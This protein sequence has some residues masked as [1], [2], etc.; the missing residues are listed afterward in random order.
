MPSGDF[1]KEYSRPLLISERTQ[2]TATLRDGVMPQSPLAETWAVSNTVLC[3]GPR[4]LRPTV[5]VVGF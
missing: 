4:V 2:V 5:R 1:R 3:L